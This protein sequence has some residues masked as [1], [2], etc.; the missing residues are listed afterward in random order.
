METVQLPA[1]E[2][3][4]LGVRVDE[5]ATPAVN[6]AEPHRAVDESAVPGDPQ[7]VVSHGERVDLVVAHA[8]V[9]G[10]DDVNRVASLL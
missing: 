7:V 4:I 6:E 3:F 1:I 8:V 2:E 10:E 5:E 9:L